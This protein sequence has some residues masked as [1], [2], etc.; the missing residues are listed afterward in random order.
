MSSAAAATATAPEII[1]VFSEEEE[2]GSPKKRRK[3]SETKGP[4]SV[5]LDLKHIAFETDANINFGALKSKV[6]LDPWVASV[7][8]GYKF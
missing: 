7:G 8:I 3:D 2:A 1:D 6:T 5:N 4:W